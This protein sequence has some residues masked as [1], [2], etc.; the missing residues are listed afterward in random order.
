ILPADDTHGALKALAGQPQ[1]AVKRRLWQVFDKPIGRM[2]QVAL[3]GEKLAAVPI[4]PHAIELLAHP[5][6]R[7]VDVVGPALGQQQAGSGRFAAVPRLGAGRQSAA[8][9]FGLGLFTAI[10]AEVLAGPPLEAD[11]L[12]AP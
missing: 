3:P 9:P 12:I 1:L 7:Q 5:P 6:A 4:G 2:K 11:R 10:L 8:D